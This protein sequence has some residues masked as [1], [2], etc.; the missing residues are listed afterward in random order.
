MGL[1]THILI[2]K[3][4]NNFFLIG[5]ESKVGAIIWSKKLM[6]DQLIL[7][8]PKTKTKTNFQFVQRILCKKKIA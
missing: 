1:Q 3:P 6:Q 7:I 8:F 4:E 5:L 2:N